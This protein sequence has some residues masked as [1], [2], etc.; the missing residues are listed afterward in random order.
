MAGKSVADFLVRTA[1]DDA[2]C[3]LA[4]TDPE[5]AFEGYDLSEQ[6]R[7]I[8]IRRDERLLGLL[9]GAVGHG[10]A[11]AEDSPQRESQEADAAP[12]PELPE[13]KL[14]L[15][16]APQVAQTPGAG[17]NVAYAASLH[18]WPADRDARADQPS[19]G[20]PPEIEWL[21]RFTPTVVA[22]GE[23]GLTVAYSAAIEPL[24]AV[25][26][27]PKPP[28][29]ANPPWNHHVDSAAAK[30][31]ARAVRASDAGGRYEKL[32]GLI[33]ALQEGDDRG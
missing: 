13:V 14:L 6:E 30:A 3:E 29:A 1:L 25:S 31:A 32:L 7:D 23:E 21:V 22:S 19:S 9:G 27:K 4:L 33:H 24:D 17:A 28:A 11:A 2:F 26:D 8:L 5:R 18:T 10:H 15:R 20:A 12:S 16:L